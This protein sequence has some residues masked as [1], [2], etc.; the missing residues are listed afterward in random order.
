MEQGGPLPASTSGG[1][2]ATQTGTS[3]G[4]TVS[5]CGESAGYA[6]GSSPPPPPSSDSPA[7]T[8][9]ATTLPSMGAHCAADVHG[10][11]SGAVPAKIAWHVSRAADRLP[12]TG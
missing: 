11:P 12:G 9:Q 6:S 2:A 7:G 5:P 10:A 1:D 4:L 3:C 8:A